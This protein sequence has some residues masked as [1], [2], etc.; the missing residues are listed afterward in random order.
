VQKDPVAALFF[1]AS[2][3]RAREAS[4]HVKNKKK[5]SLLSLAFHTSIPLF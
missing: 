5:M 3:V 4:H 1:L 2:W